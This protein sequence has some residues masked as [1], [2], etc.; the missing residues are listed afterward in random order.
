MSAEKYFNTRNLYEILQLEPKAQ[1][2]DGN[3]AIQF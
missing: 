3:M 1:I 2:Q